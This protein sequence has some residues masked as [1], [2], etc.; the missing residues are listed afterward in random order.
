FEKALKSWG[1]DSNHNSAI[2]EKFGSLVKS[3]VKDE[4]SLEF[5]STIIYSQLSKLNGMTSNVSKDDFAKLFSNI[6]DT[7]ID[8]KDFE[9]VS[10]DIF[11]KMLDGISK[12]GFK[13]N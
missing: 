3:L 13:L 1:A 8:E 2:V 12:D 10:K 7:L 4:K 11:K 9:T 5:I 6:S